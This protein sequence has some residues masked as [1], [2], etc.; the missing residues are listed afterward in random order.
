M[1]LTLATYWV[2]LQN[3]WYLML[4]Y[5]ISYGLGTAARLLVGK[6]PVVA[7]YYELLPVPSNSAIY[8]AYSDHM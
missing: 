6:I 1:V 4:E 3:T 7:T 2:C 5:L 8:V